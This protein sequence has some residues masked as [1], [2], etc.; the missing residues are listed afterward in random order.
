MVAWSAHGQ[1]RDEGEIG[2]EESSEPIGDGDWFMMRSP[3]F[4]EEPPHHVAK[5]EGGGCTGLANRNTGTGSPE[6]LPM[7]PPLIGRASTIV[8][9]QKNADMGMGAV[10]QCSPGRQ[11]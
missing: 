8:Q 6:G 7:H 11:T 1:D 5:R 3:V 4:L 10:R 9:A 2:S